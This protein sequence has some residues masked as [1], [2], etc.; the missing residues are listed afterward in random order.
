MPKKTPELEV[1]DLKSMTNEQKDAFIIELVS[2]V[3]SLLKRV[4]ELE[5]RLGK[6]SHNS[7]PVR[8]G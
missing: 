1:P 2:L 8:H 7:K 4:A 3:N 5:A 6:D